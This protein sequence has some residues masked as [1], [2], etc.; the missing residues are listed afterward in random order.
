MAYSSKL[1]EYGNLLGCK[2]FGTEAKVALFDKA[3][4]VATSSCEYAH[5]SISSSQKSDT[6]VSLFNKITS[7]SEY[8]IPL[9]TVPTKPRLI[10]L[11]NTIIFNDAY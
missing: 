1:I 8:S 10:S 3:V 5:F 6:S 2:P 11:S 4:T 9:F 7:L